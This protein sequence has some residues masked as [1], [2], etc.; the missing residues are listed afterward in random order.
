MALEFY[1]ILFHCSAPGVQGRCAGALIGLMVPSKCSGLVQRTSGP[2][3]RES[4]HQ[5]VTP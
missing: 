3:K 4:G 5:N 2:I 1:Y